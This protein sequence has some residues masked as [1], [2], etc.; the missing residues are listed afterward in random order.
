MSA[1]E[2]FASPTVDPPRRLL[3][4]VAQRGSLLVFLAILLGFAV[5]AP[6]F[7][8]VGNISNVFAQSAMLG[9]LAL[10]LTCVVIGGGSNV[11]SGG[12]DLSLAAN[13]GLCAAV[14][15]SLNNAGFEAWQAIA[16]TL[17]CGLA[18][19]AFNGVAVVVL[20]L[21]PLLA[22][23]ASMNL[24]GGL[25]LVLTQNTVLATDSALLDSLA[26]GAWLGVP[27]L[28]WV[29]LS[30]AAGLW[31]LIQHSAFGLRLYAIGE[32]PQAAKAAGLSLQRYVFASYLI[33]GGCAA[34][35]AFCSAA[36]FSG[37]TTGSGDMLLSVVAIAFLG[38][39][40]SRR[41]TANIPGT[42]LATLLLGFLI[43]GFQL[44]NISNFWV[45][46]VQGMLILLVVAF[47]GALGRQE[48]EQ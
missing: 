7:L 8:S 47:S 38:V 2:V 48:G 29:L 35:A 25:E 33:A 10:G 37:S 6:N 5:S 20:R 24:I 16:L 9:I 18:V 30:V 46:G 41:L 43:N 4:R 26:S 27:A 22:T 21:P 34:I 12:L 44:L 32:Y 15:S 19:G 28:A 17:G 39:V 14:Y 3:V 40:F 36:F 31:L 1:L 13:L 11:V 45:N 42:L 23:L